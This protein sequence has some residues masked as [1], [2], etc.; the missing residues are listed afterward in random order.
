M[1]DLQRNNSWVKVGKVLKNERVDQLWEKG[2]VAVNATQIQAEKFL[3]MDS[4][5]YWYPMY[6]TG[7]VI[8][9]HE[10]VAGEIA[11]FRDLRKP[12]FKVV[13]S[14]AQM[15]KI[16][17]SLDCLLSEGGFDTDKG[18]HFLK[19]KRNDQKLL[20]SD[21]EL[22]G[23]KNHVGI[24]LLEH[25]WDTKPKDWKIIIP[26]QK[27]FFYTE[28][29][30]SKVPLKISK[31]FFLEG[32]LSEKGFFSR[33]VSALIDGKNI[34]IKNPDHFIKSYSLATPRVRRQLLH[35]RLFSP[36]YPIEYMLSYL[37]VLLFLLFWGYTIYMRI[38][39]YKKNKNFLIILSMMALWIFIRMVKYMAPVDSV[40]YR[41][42]MYAY[43]IPQLI[44]PYF[45]SKIAFEDMAKYKFIQK[46]WKINAFIL[47]TLLVFVM[48]NDVSGLLYSEMEFVE[49]V[50]TKYGPLYYVAM[51]YIVCNIVA[52]FIKM[53]NSSSH[54]PGKF[55]FLFPFIPMLFYASYG[56]GYY[57]RIDFFYSS[58]TAF[59]AS[60]FYLLFFESCFFAGFFTGTFR[61]EHLFKMSRMR[62]ALLD[63]NLVPRMETKVKL[64]TD[65]MRIA[66]DEL[67]QK[68]S[69]YRLCQNDTKVLRGEKITGGYVVWWKDISKVKELE[70]KLYQI[71]ESLEKDIAF[72]KERGK[73][74]SRLHAT[75]WKS[76][77]YAEIEE[78]IRRDFY[79]IE[80][81][82]DDY[83]KGVKDEKE[84]HEFLTS[85]SYAVR[86]VKRKVNLML[87][88]KATDTIKEMELMLSIVD[89]AAALDM[90]P[91]AMSIGEEERTFHLWIAL[92]IY[93]VATELMS[94]SFSYGSSLVGINIRT[95]TFKYRTMFY[96]DK[97]IDVKLSAE[98][99][100]KIENM[101]GTFIRNVED[102]SDETT[103]ILIL[104]DLIKEGEGI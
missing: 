53:Q 16:V 74:E 103:Y 50:K 101:N 44:I 67:S 42:S 27:G 20:F 95:E 32:G 69:F 40:V 94:G 34:E 59:V 61:Y 41:Y 9:A 1:E 52:S 18:L 60:F 65:M 21:T 7:P 33:E 104:S 35:E 99:S 30:L 23:D 84:M 47:I 4:S 28:G 3:E 80:E 45:T 70:S 66:V 78:E 86:V 6:R 43:Y 71:S 26:E 88:G 2:V 75:R 91:D 48:T 58:D 72:L 100:K 39:D 29:I 8:V 14:K 77:V 82:V 22:Y 54:V 38:I 85:V 76:D 63:R 5:L 92:L 31:S 17:V 83:Y 89:S 15:E 93:D 56:Y 10:S 13:I 97:V 51:L 64:D 98:L 46:A 12:K 96:F 90:K 73:I 37:I 57:K 62:M 102:V 68:D 87:I 25:A 36:S 19:E 24:M 11:S 55:R 79:E 81:F 49:K